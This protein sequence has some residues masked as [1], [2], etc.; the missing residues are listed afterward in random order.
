M[1]DSHLSP[2]TSLDGRDPFDAYEE[3]RAAGP[4]IWD[5]SMQAWLVASY[6]LCRFVMEREDLFPPKNPNNPIF[7]K[8]RGGPR[9]VV[10][11]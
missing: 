1:A 6:D 3:Y 2:L 9:N 5:E 8:V 10:I 7:V 11:R 4:V